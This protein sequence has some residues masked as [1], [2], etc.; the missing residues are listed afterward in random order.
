MFI[1]EVI[2]FAPIDHPLRYGISEKLYFMVF[3]K[4]LRRY[5]EKWGP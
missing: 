2:I 3:M 5:L 1:A 4:N